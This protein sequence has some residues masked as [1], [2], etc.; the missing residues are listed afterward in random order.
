MESAARRHADVHRSNL[1]RHVHH[2]ERRAPDVSR[3]RQTVD[4]AARRAQ[5]ATEK[6]HGAAVHGVGSFVWRLKSLD[7]FAT[8]DRGY[9]V[10]QRGASV[11][12]SIS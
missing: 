2:I 8:L 9:A 7:P 10:V 6:V 12:S 5:A 1:Q 11:I 4:D 3:A